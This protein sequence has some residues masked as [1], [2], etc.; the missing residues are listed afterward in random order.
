MPR[1]D[2]VDFVAAFLVGTV[3]GVGATLLLQ[4][5][6]TPKD[7]VLRQ[8]KPYRRQMRRSFQKTREGLREGADAT[9]ELGG[10]VISAG[11]ELIGEFRAEVAKIL[12]EAR[13]ELHDMVDDQVKGLSNATRRTRRRFGA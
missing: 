1:E 6:R 5:E 8:L 10:E 13:G 4:P 3:L 11:R 9:G 12:G 7:R 2:T